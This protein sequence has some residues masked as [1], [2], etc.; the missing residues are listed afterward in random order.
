MDYDG[1]R[2][3]GDLHGDFQLRKRL[4]YKG[5]GYSRSLKKGGPG[6]KGDR[7]YKGGTRTS[8][9]YFIYNNRNNI[10]FFKFR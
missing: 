1:V 2:C 4:I 9:I 10:K 8:I 6:K 5:A 3:G 7:D